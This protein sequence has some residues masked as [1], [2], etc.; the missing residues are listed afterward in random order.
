M[1]AMTAIRLTDTAWIWPERRVEKYTE[2][3]AA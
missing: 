1:M 2:V 3:T